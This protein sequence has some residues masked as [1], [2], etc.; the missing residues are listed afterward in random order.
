MLWFAYLASRYCI[1]LLMDTALPSERQ[2]LPL[3]MASEA[4]SE[5]G[6]FYPT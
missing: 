5:F 3:P 2:Q 4:V 1:K 6:P